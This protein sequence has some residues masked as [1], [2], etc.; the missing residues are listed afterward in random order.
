V[1]IQ[2]YVQQ[3][4]AYTGADYCM[5]TLDYRVPKY[6]LNPAFKPLI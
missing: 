3:N 4:L 6:N 2:L 1:L 5:E